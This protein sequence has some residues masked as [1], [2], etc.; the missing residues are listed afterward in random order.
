M[1]FKETLFG[2]GGQLFFE[3]PANKKSYSELIGKLEVSGKEIGEKADGLMDGEYVRKVMTHIIGI[4]RWARGR[5]KVFLGD[6]FDGD[7]YDKFRP[8]REIPIGDL[9]KLFLAERKETI[10]VAREVHA[11]RIPE[12]KKVNHNDFQ[13]FSAKAWL[14]YIAMHAAQEAKSLK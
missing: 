11:R 3:R 14:N 1:G 5:L 4:E 10:M 2:L 6:A 7:E 13:G 8:A 9:R 12:D